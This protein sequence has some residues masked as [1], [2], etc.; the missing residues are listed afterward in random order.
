M[1]TIIDE[2][3]YEGEYIDNLEDGHGVFRLSDGSKYIGN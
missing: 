3:F 2:S 1:C